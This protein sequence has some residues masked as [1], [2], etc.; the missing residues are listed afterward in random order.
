MLR[1]IF[2]SIYAIKIKLMKFI[3]SQLKLL[4]IMNVTINS[5]NLTQKIKNLCGGCIIQIL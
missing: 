2:S 4:M 5:K 1:V 3:L